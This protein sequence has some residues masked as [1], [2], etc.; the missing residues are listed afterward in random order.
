[1]QK[2]IYAILIMKQNLLHYF[3]GH[4]L[5]MVMSHGLG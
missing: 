5:E 1:M 4:P 3:E 2:L